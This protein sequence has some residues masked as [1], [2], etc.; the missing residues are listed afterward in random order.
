VSGVDNKLVDLERSPDDVGLLNDIF[1]GFH[2]IKGGAGFLNATELVN[3]CHLTENLF[4]KT[5][6]QRAVGDAGNDGRHPG[7]DLGRA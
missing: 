2:T 3:V 7:G 6:Q 5:A 1:R 4:D